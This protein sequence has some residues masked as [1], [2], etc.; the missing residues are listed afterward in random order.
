MKESGFRLGR[1]DMVIL[2]NE[3]ARALI[4]DTVQ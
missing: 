1:M 4:L 2:Q 3:G